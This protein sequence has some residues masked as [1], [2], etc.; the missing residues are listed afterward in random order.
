MTNDQTIANDLLAA[1]GGANRLVQFVGAK[2]FAF[3]NEIEEKGTF[4]VRFKL[5]NAQNKL[6]ANLVKI[7][8]D[9]G[10]DLLNLEFGNI[11]R[12]LDYTIKKQLNN[13]YVD[14]IIEIFE[15]E[16]ALFLKF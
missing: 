14:Q 3:H 5:P 6:K 4:Y 2:Q 11:N 8:L 16:T 10:L 7:E 1:F 9:V 12:N 15:Q 13:L